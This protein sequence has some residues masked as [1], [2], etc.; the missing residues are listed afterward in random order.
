MLEIVKPSELDLAR[1]WCRAAFLLPATD[2]DRAQ[3]P[4][5]FSH[6]TQPATTMLRNWQSIQ[7]E[8][9]VGDEYS[10][11]EITFADPQGVLEL[12]CEVKSYHAYPAVEWVAY[13]KNTGTVDSGILADILPLDTLFPLEPALPC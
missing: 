9:T 13:L 11:D 1:D 4:V 10:L 12:R 7:A 3:L 5:T 2:G 8:Q 6:H